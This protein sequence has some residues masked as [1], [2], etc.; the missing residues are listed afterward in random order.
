MWNL[1][2][3]M[4]ADSAVRE[5]K[6]ASKPLG[7]ASELQQLIPS[8]TS[9]L[10][11]AYAMRHEALAEITDRQIGIRVGLEAANLEAATTKMLAHARDTAI[12]KLAKGYTDVIQALQRANAQ[13]L[14]DDQALIAL[15]S[16]ARRKLLVQDKKIRLA[17]APCTS[18][19]V[20]PP[21]PP[22]PPP[23][24]Y[25]CLSAWC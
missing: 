9:S 22:P 19:T 23:Y 12:E 2:Q 20:C 18:H 4:S 21:L 5:I 17:S 10:H 11:S 3:V 7:K 16:A 14:V 1:M 13:K 25:C 15:W 6:D 24:P 8:T